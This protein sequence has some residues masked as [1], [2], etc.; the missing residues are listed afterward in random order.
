M[1]STS[2]PFPPMAGA[3]SA[4]TCGAIVA[5][6]MIVPVL[7]TKFLRS[8]CSPRIFSTTALWILRSV[9][10]LQEKMQPACFQGWIIYNVRACVND[11]FV[12]HQKQNGMGRIWPI[13]FV[14]LAGGEN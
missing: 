4:H 3:I 6:A 8:M 1:G 10:L 5:P 7:L 11:Y 9:R 13:P 14:L 12:G 2:R